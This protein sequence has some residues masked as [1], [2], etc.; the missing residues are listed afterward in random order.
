MTVLLT[1]DGLSLEDLWRVAVDGERLEVAPEVDERL[2]AG[3]AV[4]ER[5]LDG[6]R[7]V[8]GLNTGLGHQRDRRVSREEL[9]EYQV[10]IVVGHAGAVG[11]PLPDEHVRALMAARV[12]G[13]AAGG[14]GVTPAAC[15]ALVDLLNAGVHP[16]VPEVGSV[17]A[18]DL[19]HLAAVAK[20][21]IG[22]GHA[23]LDGETLKGAEALE[24]A[25]LEPYVL[26][27]KDGLALVSANSASIGMGALAVRQAERLVDLADAVVALSLETLSANPSPFD[28]RAARAK[29]VPGSVLTAANVRAHLQGSALYDPATVLSVQ[30]SL[31]LRTVPQVHG[32]LREQ[33]TFARRAVEAELNGMGDNPLVSVEDDEMISNGNFHP[34]VLA[35]AFEGLRVALAHVGQISERRLHKSTLIHFEA[36]ASLLEAGEVLEIEPDDEEVHGDDSDVADYEAPGLLAYAAA[37]L[38]AELKSLADP[39]TFDVPPLDFDIEDHATLAPLA[40]ATA[41]R[42]LQKLETILVIEA[43]TSATLLQARRPRPRLGTGT[44]ALYGQVRQAFRSLDPDSSGAD[45]VEIVR[46]ALSP[47]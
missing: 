28:E 10:R 6:D 39:V 18:A 9:M 13:F 4:V 36:S 37:E 21:L 22:R 44:A 41:R 20:V 14:S 2:A 11:P 38:A 25:G 16:V 15:H 7:L 35:I 40:V 29:G 17:G 1:A 27:P 30:D 31:S 47:R 19:M 33:L 43:I 5:M 24:R 26:Q 8:Y 45:A 34:M 42:S 12:A 23:R 32:A 3:R 46:A